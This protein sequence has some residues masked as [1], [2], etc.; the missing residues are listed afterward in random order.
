ML[1]ILQNKKAVA[2]GFSWAAGLIAIAL[3]VIFAIFF[4]IAGKFSQKSVVINYDSNVYSS[5]YQRVAAYAIISDFNS[6]HK[7]KILSEIYSNPIVVM[8]YVDKFPQLFIPNNY[9]YSYYP[10]ISAPYFADNLYIS[11]LRCQ[12]KYIS[13]SVKRVGANGK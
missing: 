3:I 12:N 5:E 8:G 2:E 9:S 4:S 6:T 1:A 10:L 11:C 7:G 13:F